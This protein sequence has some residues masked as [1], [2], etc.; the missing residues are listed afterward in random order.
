MSKGILN[1]TVDVCDK[2]PDEY[3]GPIAARFRQQRKPEWFDNEYV[4]KVI[5]EIDN[6]EVIRQ[7]SLIDRRGKGISPL[8]LSST[9]KCVLL[10]YFHPEYYY[11]NSMF[12]KNAW[13]YICDIVDSGSTISM[14]IDADFHPESDLPRRIPMCVNGKM[15]SDYET[16]YEDVFIEYKN[17]L[18]EEADERARQWRK[19]YDEC[20]NTK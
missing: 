16:D 20:Y 10:M 14:S 9:T 8:E 15:V 19:L 12:G 17:K 2:Y 5:R 7:E 13:P 6:A 11:L 3:V 1:L 18:E 4:R